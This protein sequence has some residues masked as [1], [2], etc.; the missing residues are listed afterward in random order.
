[1]QTKQKIAALEAEAKS[2]RSAGPTA[3]D[4]LNANAAITYGDFLAMVGLQDKKEEL[5]EYLT[6]GAELDQLKQMDEEELDEDILDDLGLDEDIK[7]KFHEALRS[8]Q[9]ARAA[10]RSHS[11]AS[12]LGRSERLRMLAYTRSRTVSLPPSLPLSLPLRSIR[13]TGGLSW[14]TIRLTPRGSLSEHQ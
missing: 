1:M 5:T 2:V 10:G 4:T 6:E 12:V 9:Q 3:D 14:R 7:T 8:L 13:W 11:F